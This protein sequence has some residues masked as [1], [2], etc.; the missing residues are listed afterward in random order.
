[1]SEE[2]SYDN[3]HLMHPLQ[4]KMARAG[5]DWSVGDLARKAGVGDAIVTRFETDG[6]VSPED[7]GRLFDALELGGAMFTAQDEKLGVTV[8]YRDR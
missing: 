1:M 2:P 4:C 6:T 8:H 7:L 5:L 3:F